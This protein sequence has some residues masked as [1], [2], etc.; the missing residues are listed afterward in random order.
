MSKHLINPVKAFQQI[1]DNYILY[2]ETAFGTRFEAFN[3]LRKALLNRDRVFYREP[4]IELLPQYKSS[5]LRINDLEERDL[6]GLDQEQRNIFKDFI[7]RG[8]MDYGNAPGFEGIYSHQA[9]M[10]REALAGNNCVI[11]SGTGSGKTESFLLPMIAQLIKEVP[12]W[13]AAGRPGP[14]MNNWWRTSQNYTPSRATV[15]ITNAMGQMTGYQL[16]PAISQRAHETRPAA[17]RALIL[18]PMNALVE[19]Q[20]TRLRQALDADEI[21]QYLDAQQGGNRI[22]FGRYNASTPVAGKLS[23]EGPNGI[24]RNDYKIK[25]LKEEL[26]K[27]E[28]NMAMVEAHLAGHGELN[29]KE[30]QSIFQRLYGQEANGVKSLTAEM[31]SRFDMQATPPDIL[32]TNYSMLG[33]MLM[34]EIDDSIFEQTKAW[35]EADTSHVFHLIIDELHLYRGTP[36]TEIACLVRLLINRL[37]LTPDSD[38]LRILASSASL[39]DADPKAKAFLKEFFGITNPD[40]ELKI[41]KGESELLDTFTGP[42]HLP[43]QAFTPLS[44]CFEADPQAFENKSPAA[45]QACRIA[46]QALAEAFGLAASGNTGFEQL[47]RLLNDN[48]VGLESRLSQTFTFQ[49]QNQ[50][51]ASV[52]ESRA[53][54]LFAKEDDRDALHRYFSTALFGEVPELRAATE[55]LVIARGLFDVFNGEEFAKTKLQ[56]FRFHYFFRNIEGLWATASQPAPG[57]P[58]GNLHG[59]AKITDETDH[60]K[61]VFEVLYCESCGTVFY[62]GKKLRRNRAFGN[63]GFGGAALE[64]VATSPKIEGLPEQSVQVLVERR[65]YA[66]YGIFWP[67]GHVADNQTYDLSLDRPENRFHRAFADTTPGTGLTW[68]WSAA[69]LHMFSGDVLMEHDAADAS[70]DH[71]IKGYLFQV[72]DL[73][74]EQQQELA[75]DY[76]ALPCNCP[77]CATDRYWAQRRRSP[78]RGFRAGFSKTSQIFAKELFYQLP[79]GK[80]KRKLVSFSDSREDAAAIANGIERNHYQDLLRDEMIK[81]GQAVAGQREVLQKL[82]AGEELAPPATEG[83][84][85]L[86]QTVRN[87]LHRSRDE[88]EEFARPFLAQLDGISNGLVAFQNFYQSATHETAPIIKKLFTEG[89]NPAGCDW[90]DQSFEPSPGVFEDWPKCFTNNGNWSD[91]ANAVFKDSIKAKIKT[92]LGNMLFGRLFYGLEA[93]AFGWTTVNHL[94]QT[95]TEKLAH[96]QLQGL[97][98]VPVFT[99]VVDSSIRILAEGYRRTLTETRAQEGPYSALRPRHRL[100]KYIAAVARLYQVADPDRLG[101]AVTDYLLA[102]GHRGLFIQTDHLFMRFATATAEVYACGKCKTVHLHPSGGVCTFCRADTQHGFPSAGNK[103]AIDVW[104]TNYLA[105]GLVQH[106]PTIKLHCEELTGQTDDQFQRQR[107]FRDYIFEAAEGPANIRSIDLLSVTTTLEVGV[108]IG[109]L[110]AVMLANMPPQRFNYQQRVG[111]GGRRG[112]AYSLILTLCRG[113]SHDEFYFANPHRITGDAPPTP[114]LS[115]GQEEILKRMLVKELLRQAFKDFG[116]RSGGT[117]GEFGLRGD[118]LGQTRKNDFEQWLNQ[119]PATVDSLILVLND[120]DQTKLPGYRQYIYQQLLPEIDLAV[121]NPDIAASELSETLAEAGL[122][123]MFGMPSRVRVLYG[124]LNNNKHT[125]QI[126]SEL[127]QVDRPLDVAVTEFFPGSQKTKDKKIITAIGFTPA[128]LEFGD[129]WK[130]GRLQTGIHY[131][132]GGEPFSLRRILVNCTACKSYFKTFRIGDPEIGLLQNE[133]PHCFAPLDGN[134]FEIRTPAAFRTDFSP[135]VNSEDDTQ[136]QLS[137]PSMFAEAQEELQPVARQNAQVSLA[138]LDM[139]WRINDQ[140]VTGQLSDTT[141]KFPFSK[142]TRLTRQWIASDFSRSEPREGYEYRSFPVPGSTVETIKIAANKFTNIFRIQPLHVPDGIRLNPFE[143]LT[144]P[145]ALGV[146]AAYYSAA[147]ILQRALAARQDVDPTEIEITDI[148]AVKSR[149]GKSIA[150]VI[151]ADELAN[152]SGFV[153]DLFENLDREYNYFNH[154]LNPEP[155]TYFG[156]IF[157]PAHRDTCKDACYECLKVYRNMP[158]HGLIDWRLGMALLRLLADSTVTFGLHKEELPPEMVDWWQ[159]ATEIRDSFL[160]SF[161]EQNGAKLD[162]VLPGI[163]VSGAQ[164]R[165]VFFVHPFWERDA[166]LNPLLGEAV[167]MAGVLRYNVIDTFNALRRPGWCY[168]QIA[169]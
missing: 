104:Q 166:A 53:I 127:S 30:V 9:N 8:L 162:G 109:A 119:H 121:E 54:A 165:A 102:M 117:H 107:H 49:Q 89:V 19:D 68:Q 152:G 56:R 46:A 147:F 88:D 57:M 169:L 151:L 36:G 82:R 105:A 83:E 113:R 2:V 167:A 72:P 18:Y 110:Q 91:Q 63:S 62:G 37:G 141:N 40:K 161:Y 17:V 140:A 93:S 155:G 43:A 42:L 133:C 92:N 87:L 143:H 80:G 163:L 52:K 34:R 84:R 74:S 5:G 168:E 35:L 144:N 47:C 3:H 1:K 59:S 16:H 123:P 111:R 145:S 157:S 28:D 135:G 61:R 23:K 137:R 71:F 132:D 101:E 160:A 27:I 98:P 112:Q 4:W 115:T 148:V 86:I 79:E 142:S 25:Q 39:D 129:R 164:P 69:S 41:I 65:S 26:Q 126:Y 77:H 22:Y 73:D 134:I 6:P 31:R 97:L 24:V 108:D 13:P 60:N 32:I 76:Q 66:D 99:Q 114:F 55:G 45:E 139:T 103:R 20:M 158:Y 150:Q 48:S 90:E 33:I 10:M 120:G 64:L 131:P 138:Q 154:I 100:K 58:V 118:W 51:G 146:K 125:R 75:Q 128:G 136:L 67:L 149:N 96:Y 29:R 15:A 159:I 44:A 21:Q 106:R 116:E 70:P 130:D 156:Q 95:I 12:L 38:Q 122:L 78:I 85:K 7:S 153:K 50:A 14:D 94:D 11:T 124:G 81:F